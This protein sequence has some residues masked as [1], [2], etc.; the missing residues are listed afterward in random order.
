MKTLNKTIG[1]IENRNRADS[2]CNRVD[3]DTLIVQHSLNQFSFKYRYNAF[4]KYLRQKPLLK[5][6]L[7]N[8]AAFTLL[9]ADLLIKGIN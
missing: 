6:S 8:A 3:L 7:Y 1:K 5:I 9:I 2:N 4:K